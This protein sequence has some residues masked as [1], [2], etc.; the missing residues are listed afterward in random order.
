MRAAKWRASL[1]LAPLFLAANSDAIPIVAPSMATAGASAAS[2]SVSFSGLRS[3]KGYLRACL[4]R[5]PR[6]FPNC[7]RD[8]HAMK[9]SIVASPQ[10]RLSFAN[11]P[12][13]DYAL[14]VLHDENGN[15]RADMLMGIPREGV[16]FSENPRLRFSAPKFDAA[17]FRVGTSALSMEVRLQYFL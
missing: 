13:G 17:R 15:A 2:L 8:P 12:S 14:S 6:F 1:L 7:D 9:E 10:A 4:T 16:G 11:L 3:A 5:D